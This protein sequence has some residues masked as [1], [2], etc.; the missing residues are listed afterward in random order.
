MATN[1]RRRRE[2]GYTTTVFCGVLNPV[3]RINLINCIQKLDVTAEHGNVTW[4]WKIAGLWKKS[5]K[6]Q[7]CLDTTKYGR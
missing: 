3:R 1:S 2:I 6:R 7:F 4:L 5:G